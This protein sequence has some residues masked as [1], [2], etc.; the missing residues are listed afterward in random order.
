M[1][2]YGIPPHQWSAHDVS[3]FNASLWI[4]PESSDQADRWFQV[5]TFGISDIL[6]EINFGD[7]DNEEMI[8]MMGRDGGIDIERVI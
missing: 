3:T 7:S 1:L 2:D 8:D 5:S 4:A 6:R